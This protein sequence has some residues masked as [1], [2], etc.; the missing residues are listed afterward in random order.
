MNFPVS[1]GFFKVLHA[2]YMGEDHVT[3]IR[4]LVGYISYQFFSD[5]VL[6]MSILSKILLILIVTSS[7]LVVYQI[8]E[9][10]QRVI[11]LF[12]ILSELVFKLGF[13]KIKYRRKICL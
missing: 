8:W 3:P 5:P 7:L 12:L 1:E 11:L 10:K 2:V 4:S 13:V 9:D 6:A